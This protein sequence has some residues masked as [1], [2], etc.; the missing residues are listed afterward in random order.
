MMGAMAANASAMTQICIRLPAQ[1]CHAIII[2]CDA[3][4]YTLNQWHLTAVTHGDRSRV[5]PS[6]SYVLPQH[7][8]LKQW[9]LTAV[10]H[11][12]WSS[13][14]TH[15]W[16]P[17]HLGANGCSNMK[18]CTLVSPTTT[19]PVL[20]IRQR[21]ASPP[22]SRPMRMLKC[23]CRFSSRSRSLRGPALARLTHS[24]SCRCALATEGFLKHTG[25]AQAELAHRL[26]RP[27]TP[28]RTHPG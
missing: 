9:Q 13:P 1:P 25:A 12:Y 16:A 22:S 17:F 5:M 19:R 8:T 15:T 24:H 26:C 23:G 7:N 10:T 27:T 4:A 14:M 11:G 28:C 20:Q 6:S 21:G 2:L 3:T 18:A